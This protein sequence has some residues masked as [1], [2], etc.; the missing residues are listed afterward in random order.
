MKLA[1]VRRGAAGSQ[2]ATVVG[3]I[4]VVAI[5]AVTSLGLNTRNLMGRVANTLTNVVE[6]AA[7][8]A[9]VTIVFQPPAPSGDPNV[10][11]GPATLYGHYWYLGTANRSCDQVCAAVG[12]ANLSN[13][14]VNSFANACG[15]ASAS[16]VS[17]WFYQNG[18]PGGF[19][20]SSGSTSARS[21]GY[22]YAGNSHYGKCTSATGTAAIG[23]FPGETGGSNRL[24]ACPCFAQ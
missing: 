6:P 13:N 21:L 19:N 9:P 23:T 7:P 5:A 18:N 22:G 15:G 20:N 14:L 1:R 2:Y 3:L 4:A 8:A 12:G 11:G 10:A 16:D 24:L 17:R